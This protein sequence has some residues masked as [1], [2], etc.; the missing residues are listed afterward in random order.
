MSNNLLSL[1]SN[2][3]PGE[4]GEQKRK[5]TAAIRPAL[6]ADAEAIARA[7]VASW[8]ATYQGI[9]SDE[10]LANLSVEERARNWQ[11]QLE[12]PQ[13]G[14]FVYVAEQDGNILG[15]ASG[16]PERSGDP[17][18]KGEI[19][20]LYLVK[21]CQRQ[22]I[23]QMLVEASVISL[24]A[25]GIESMLIWVL[26]D[27]PSRRFYEAVGGKFL[28]EQEIEIRG[29]RLMEVAYGWDNLCNMVKKHA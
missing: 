26:R 1:T 20:A 24:L 27:N 17:L 22:G 13:P 15:F 16:G 18:Y 23:G 4:R 29:Q 19:Y 8:R 6:S 2:P 25:D 11:R 7:H 28:R 9:V 14:C 10:I 5:Q 3:S 21:E 12:A